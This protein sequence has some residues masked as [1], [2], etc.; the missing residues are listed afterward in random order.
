MDNYPYDGHKSTEE[1][2]EQYKKNKKKFLLNLKRRYGL[3]N[4]FKESILSLN[5][6][7]TNEQMNNIIIEYIGKMEN[8]I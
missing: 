2:I 6:N 8:K 3:N 5:K 4:V 7:K 1:S